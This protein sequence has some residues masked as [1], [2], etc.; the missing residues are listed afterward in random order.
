MNKNR[1]CRILFFDKIRHYSWRREEDL[2][3][4]YLLGTHDFQSCALNRSAISASGINIILNL[5]KKI[6]R[7]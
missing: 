7:F 2:N 1:K 4:R 3:L 5:I 6:K